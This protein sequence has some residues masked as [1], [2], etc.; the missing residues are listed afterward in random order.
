MLAGVAG[1]AALAA[2]IQGSVHQS[3]VT[4]GLTGGGAGSGYSGGS[5]SGSTHIGGAERPSANGSHSRRA[6]THRANPGLSVP[7]PN[8]GPAS[9]G[10]NGS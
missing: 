7:A 10:S 4:G 2:G 8:A 1:T 9:G 5:T 3:G 6:R